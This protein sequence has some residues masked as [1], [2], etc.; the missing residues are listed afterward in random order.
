MTASAL[1]FDTLAPALHGGRDD[2]AAKAD[3]KAEIAAAEKR[4]PLAG[5][6]LAGALVASVK[7]LPQAAP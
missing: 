3:L 1:A 7:L 5:V 2:R 6:A 4:M